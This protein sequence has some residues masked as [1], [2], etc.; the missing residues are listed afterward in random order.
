MHMHFDVLFRA[1][2]LL[3][4]T[5]GDP[6]TQGAVVAG[7]QG[8]GVSTPRAAVVAAATVGFAKDEHMPN[9]IILAMGI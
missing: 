2:E 4:N 3:I 9:G 8:I 5:V 6:G 1:G 7:I